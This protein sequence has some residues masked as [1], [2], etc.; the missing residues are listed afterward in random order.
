MNLAKHDVQVSL[1]RP[2]TLSQE[3]RLYESCKSL[4]QTFEN[5]V[6]GR[7]YILESHETRR[8]PRNPQALLRL[9]TTPKT[10]NT[11]SMNLSFR[12]SANKKHLRRRSPKRLA[13]EMRT[14]HRDSSAML[15]GLRRQERQ[16]TPWIMSS[17]NDIPPSL[18]HCG[19][20]TTACPCCSCLQIYL[21]PQQFLRR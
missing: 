5:F 21:L 14:M 13:E 11:S 1:A 2:K 15:Q 17:G 9:S 20:L 10:S 6:Y 18:T 16:S 19:T 8:R 4:F 12:N 3:L 7:E